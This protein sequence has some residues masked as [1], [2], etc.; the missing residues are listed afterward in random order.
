VTQWEGVVTTVADRVRVAGSADGVANQALFN[1]PNAVAVD[2]SGKI[3]VADLGYATIREISP[4]GAVTTLAGDVSSDADDG[5]G[6]AA[7]FEFSLGMAID[8]AGNYREAAHGICV[9]RL[10]TENPSAGKCHII[11]R[12]FLSLRE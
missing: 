1:L 6:G 7:R 10:I 5:S 11:E 3:F 2:A 4:S 8:L 9:R 12:V